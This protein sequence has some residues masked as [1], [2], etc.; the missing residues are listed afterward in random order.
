MWSRDARTAKFFCSDNGQR[1]TDKHFFQRTTDIGQRTK[2]FSGGQR[3]RT[4][5]SQKLTDNGPRTADNGLS[6]Q[7]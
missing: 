3:T 6:V 1:T 5:D 7:L 2:I 4:T